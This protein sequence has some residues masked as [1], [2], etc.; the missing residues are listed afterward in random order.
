MPATMERKVAKVT[1]QKLGTDKVTSSTIGDKL[2]TGTVVLELRIHGVSFSRKVKADTIVS[3]DLEATDEETKDATSMLHVS[4]DIIDREEI[5]ELQ[6]LTY[7]FKKWLNNRKLPM[8]GFLNAG[9]FVIP[10]QFVLEVDERIEKFRAERRALIEKF[11]EG[12]EG[13]K[14]DA[15]KRLEPLGL[16]NALDYPS[17]EKL[18]RAFGVTAKFMA[19]GVPTVLQD[20]DKELF[21]KYEAQ[22]AQEVTEAGEELKQALRAGMAEYV[23]Y[24]ADL[25]TP[26][27]RGRKK[28]IREDRIQQM[29][30]F[31]NT[32]NVRNLA[33]D[34]ELRQLVGRARRLMTGVDAKK[35]KGNEDLR[36]DIQ[37][38]F[39]EI[40][41]ALDPLIVTRGGRTVEFD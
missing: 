8:P 26:D 41:Q 19:F 25:M 6:N 18:Q 5:Q 38:S 3:R 22:I 11:L 17:V 23:D 35:L 13:F 33:D 20:L 29:Q 10:I 14:E 24:M 12:Y 21:K 9:M 2:V 39:A 37:A 36:A 27:A 7:K 30:D 16:Y 34:E 32:F 1:K 31:F 40:K 15:R 28:A 4:K